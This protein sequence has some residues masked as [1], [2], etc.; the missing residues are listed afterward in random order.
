MFKIYIK[1]FNKQ[2]QTLVKTITKNENKI[3]YN[4]LSYKILL[5]DNTFHEV[6]FLK[7]YGSFYS[8]LENLVTR[9]TTVNNANVNQISFKI[10]LMHGYNN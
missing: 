1:S 2:S 6:S 5:L 7:K 4:N 10:N 3:N 8:L 9:K